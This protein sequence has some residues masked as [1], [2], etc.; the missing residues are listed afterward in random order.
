MRNTDTS[1]SSTLLKQLSHLLRML[2]QVKNDNMIVKRP[3]RQERACTTFTAR[4]KLV[5]A[6]DSEVETK[7][8]Y[9]KL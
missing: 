8:I 9:S 7:I 6:S 5:N 4:Y 2:L 1:A 3:S